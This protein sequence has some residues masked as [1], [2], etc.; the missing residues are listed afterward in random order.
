[1]A[2][3]SSLGSEDRY[4]ELLLRFA[5]AL[6]PVDVAIQTHPEA[7]LV[8]DVADRAV[9]GP[10]VSDLRS[11]GVPQ[12]TIDR[13]SEPSF[14]IEP[15][16]A[17]LLG[18]MYTVEGSSLGG[19][20]ISRMVR[21]AIP[22]APVA[23]FDRYGESIGDRWALLRRIINANL[24]TNCDC[25]GAVTAAGSVFARFMPSPAAS[26]IGRIDAGG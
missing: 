10:L 23:Y 21:E 9:R 12:A 19:R 20:V 1:M 26:D 17:H 4:R 13:L 7:R 16:A 15:S 22:Q 14:V 6:L 11:L 8:P 18:A 5:S 2:V 3:E 24:K 25:D